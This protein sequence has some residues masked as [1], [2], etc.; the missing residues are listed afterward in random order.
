MRKIQKRWVTFV[1]PVSLVKRCI[2][3]IQTFLTAYLRLFHFINRNGFRNAF[4]FVW[5][6]FQIFVLHKSISSTWCFQTPD[7]PHRVTVTWESP[8][9]WSETI[10]TQSKWL[11]FFEFAIFT[12]SKWQETNAY[13]LFRNSD[14]TKIYIHWS[15]FIRINIVRNAWRIFRTREERY[16]E[17]SA[18]T[19]MIFHPV[20]F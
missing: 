15:S 19:A 18:E 17:N 5:F 20:L 8:F 11:S 13:T 12:T 6:T 14:S 7:Q 2:H 16:H 9:Q 4:C 10:H 3:L 1:T